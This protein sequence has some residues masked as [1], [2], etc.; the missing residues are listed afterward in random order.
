M[1]S[2][3]LQKYESPQESQINIAEILEPLGDLAKSGNNF[4]LSEVRITNNPDHLS[5]PASYYEMVEF[6]ESGKVAASRIVVPDID[7][8]HLTRL[9]KERAGQFSAWQPKDGLGYAFTIETHPQGMS[10]VDAFN[11]GKLHK[12]GIEGVWK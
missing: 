7:L 5:L 8:D 12:T 1:E 2:E 3:S 6:A 4:S 9:L 11:Q 10:R